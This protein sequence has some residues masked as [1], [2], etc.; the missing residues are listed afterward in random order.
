MNLYI[1]NSVW[2]WCHFPGVWAYVGEEQSAGIDDWRYN[3]QSQVQWLWCCI[4]TKRAGPFSFFAN[5]LNGL[6]YLDTL[7]EFLMVI[8]FW[9]KRALMAHCS[10]TMECCH[11]FTLLFIVSWFDSFHRSD[12]AG[13]PLFFWLLFFHEFT[14]VSFFF[15]GCVKDALCVLPILTTLLELTGRVQALMA[16]LTPTMLMK[17]CGVNF[18]YRYV[19]C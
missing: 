15:W 16:T 7:E 14:S 17:V 4:Q 10:I 13:V 8:L 9:K 18:T 6:V 5:M 2:W 1:K 19:T 12:L 3:G 11:I